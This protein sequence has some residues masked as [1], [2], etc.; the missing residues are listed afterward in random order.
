MQLLTEEP[1]VPNV[2]E[3]RGISKIYRSGSQE[4]LVEVQA[5]REVD[6]EITDGEFVAIMGPSGSGKSTLMHIIGLLD[7]PNVGA[8]RLA[9]VEVA[10]MD[11][12]E[13]ANLRNHKI[14][15]IFQAFFL[16]PRLTALENVE[17]PLIYRGMPVAERRRKALAA[18]DDVGLSDRGNHF[19]N[20]LSGGQKQRVAIARALVQEPDL[21]LADEPTGNLD[22]HATAEVLD[23]F[24]SLHQAGK[25]I[26]VV[27]HEPDVGARAQRIV[28]MRDGRIEA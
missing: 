17:L 16:L 3:M 14:G 15:F 12:I 27:T 23:L 5:L 1:S 7:T 2:V 9:N 13:R 20:E 8:Y 4:R 22:S 24:A 21:L 28:H 19:P 6:L 11:E 25:T 26:M 18:L 10:G